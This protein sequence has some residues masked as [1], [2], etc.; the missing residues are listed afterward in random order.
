M[1][2]V[3]AIALLAG[4]GLIAQARAT[5]R[6]PARTLQAA[7]ATCSTSYCVDWQLLAGGLGPMESATFRLEST[8]GQTMAGRFSSDTFH[9]EA[10]YWAGVNRGVRL[11]LPVT[12][13]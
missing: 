8:L 6:P 1:F 7:T 5:A 4:A 10:G 13:K 9:L 11:F 2:V 3:L 12:I